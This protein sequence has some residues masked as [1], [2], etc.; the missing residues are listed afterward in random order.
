MK[1]HSIETAAVHAGEPKEK[2]FGAVNFPIFQSSTYLY[3]GETSY[4]NVKY[5]RLNNTPNHK[6]LSQKLAALE[7][8]ETALV[9]ASGMA[10]ISDS[11]LAFLQTGDHMMAQNCVYGGTRDL[12]TREFS[13]FGIEVSFLENLSRTTL[14]KHLKSNTRVLLVES[15]TNPLMQVDNLIEA[16]NFSREKGLVSMIDNTFASPVN[17]KPAGIGFDLVLHSCTKYLNGHSDI[18]A[19]AVVGK[20]EHIKLINQ[21]NFHFGATLDPHACFLLQRG[22]KT[23]P[24]RIRQQNIN[25]AALAEFLAGHPGVEKVNYPGLP[26]SGGDTE[27]KKLFSGFSGMLSVELKNAP[28]RTRGFIDRLEIPVEAPSLGGVESLVSRPSVTSHSGLSPAERQVMGI[29]DFLVRISVGVE[30]TDDL[31]DDFKQALR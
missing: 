15:I 18:V 31:I 11:L 14:E 25:A 26:G 13:R 8:G 23:M 27:T 1:K 4:E 16:A 3:S 12:V 9:T 19:G 5:I 21:R 24:L 10:A 30:G 2:I 22:I 20:A 29:S 17:F 6:A 7:D 28:S